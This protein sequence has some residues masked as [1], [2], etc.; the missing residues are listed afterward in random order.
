MLRTLC[1]ALML[2]FVGARLASAD[3]VS[4]LVKSIDTDKNTI[5]ITADDKDQTFSVEK[6]SKVWQPG[7]TKKM[8]KSD[9][10][11]GLSGLK[12]GQPVVLTTEKKND[13]DVVTEIKLEE[14]AT[15]KKKKANE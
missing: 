9:V 1:L 12:A 5:T 13:K 14:A 6:E 11:G 7:R 2:V 15:K 4:G 10:P 8:P 3:T